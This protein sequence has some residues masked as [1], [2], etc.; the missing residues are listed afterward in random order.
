MTLG[1]KVY[2]R[3]DLPR[4]IELSDFRVNVHADPAVSETVLRAARFIV[5][6]L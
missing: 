2:W 1:I 6:F 5:S 4:R 3:Y